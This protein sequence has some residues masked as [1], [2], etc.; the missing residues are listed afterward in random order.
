MYALK[1]MDVNSFWWKNLFGF[2]QLQNGKNIYC[3]KF[4]ILFL[5]YKCETIVEHFYKR[6]EIKGRYTC[7]GFCVLGWMWQ[8]CFLGLILVAYFVQI[9]L[10]PVL[11]L[12]LYLI[13]GG[14]LWSK[15]KI[16]LIPSFHWIRWGVYS[17]CQISPTC[18]K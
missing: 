18:R 2:I 5:L 16:I 8:H 1:M 12:Y 3:L 6:T 17:F 9:S 10:F 14:L 13:S 4:T 11:S 15:I 7:C